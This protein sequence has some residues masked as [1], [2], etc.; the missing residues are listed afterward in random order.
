MI[1]AGAS[2]GGL[3]EV[4]NNAQDKPFGLLLLGELLE[5]LAQVGTWTQ[6]DRFGFHAVKDCAQ[7][8]IFSLGTHWASRCSWRTS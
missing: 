3:A 8:P 1:L 4:A 5:A 7:A 2:K 6:V